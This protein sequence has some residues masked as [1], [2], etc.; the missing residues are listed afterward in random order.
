MNGG[1][2]FHVVKS[3]SCVHLAATAG[4]VRTISVANP[5]APVMAATYKSPGPDQADGLEAG[6][7][8]VCVADM[9]GGFRILK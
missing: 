1:E 2:A 5:A 7:P 6:G 8:Y 3:S 9:R 4:G